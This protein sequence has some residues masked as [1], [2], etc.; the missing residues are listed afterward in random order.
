[1]SPRSFLRI[2]GLEAS[3]KLPA[4]LRHNIFVSV[5]TEHIPRN[6]I[7]LTYLARLNVAGFEGAVG[8]MLHRLLRTDQG[9][10]YYSQNSPQYPVEGDWDESKGRFYRKAGIK[11]MARLAFDVKSIV[12]A[13]R[14]GA[15]DL[16][17]YAEAAM[18]GVTDFPGYYDNPAGR[19]P[20]MA[21]ITLPTFGVL[22]A[23]GVEAEYYG[24]R[25]RNDMN[26]EATPVPIETHI[27]RSDGRGFEFVD[28]P[29]NQDGGKKARTNDF[30]WAVFA[31]KRI[32]KRLLVS[33]HAAS[34]HFRAPDGNGLQLEELLYAPDEW[35]WQV[36]LSTEF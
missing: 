18:L 34:D 20:V 23:A 8:V 17:L 16:R 15:N 35:H 7:S 6:D 33:L 25:W 11:L 14:L 27:P 9:N 2:T 32:G 30:K 28:D 19:I 21:G 1:L 13:T 31:E 24:S 4:A 36:T 12:G 29:A 5:E 26:A 22:D 3:G 10:F